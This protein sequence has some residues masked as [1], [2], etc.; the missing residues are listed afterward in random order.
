ML[1][2]P[3][4]NCSDLE[5]K[6]V[7]EGPATSLTDEDCPDLQT[8]QAC[9]LKTDLQGGWQ[10]PNHYVS[11]SSPISVELGRTKVALGRSCCSHC[12]TYSQQL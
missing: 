5:S 11:L 1:D 6:E 2:C 12:L 7:T 3:L 9:D 4:Y 8:S 10:I